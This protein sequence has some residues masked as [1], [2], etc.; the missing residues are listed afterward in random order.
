MAMTTVTVNAS[1]PVINAFTAAPNPIAVD[2]TVTLSWDVLGADTVRVLDGT[3]E[4]ANTTMNVGTVGVTVTSTLTVYTLEVANV[5][6]GNTSQV[7]VYGHNPAS[8]VSFTATPTSFVGTTTVTL[9]WNAV[10]VQNLGITLNGAPLSGFTPIANTMMTTN[11]TGTFDVVVSADATFV[12]SVDSLGGADSATVNVL[13]VIAET[14]PN[15]TPATAV[16]L[17]GAPIDGT[18]GL[19]GEDIDY[20][21]VTVPAGGWVRIETSDGMG[22]CG[23]DTFVD[24]FDT[25]GVTPLLSD[26]NGGNGNCSLIDP[27]FDTVARNMAGGTYYVA[28]TGSGAGAYQLDVTSGPAAC[29]NSLLETG[30]SCDDGNTVP[31]DGC[32][33]TCAIEP[34]NVYTAPGAPAT[35]AESIDPAGEQDFYRIVVTA[36]AI[37]TIETFVD[38][39]AGTCPSGTD[40]LIRLYD[41]N[42]NQIGSDDDDGVGACSLITPANDAAAVMAPGT[43]YLRVEEFGNNGVIPSYE[44]VFSSIAGNVCGNG[45]VEPANGE[46]CDDGNLSAGDGCDAT[47]QPELL[48]DY[49]APGAL[50]TAT[51]SLA[52]TQVDTIRITATSSV[53]IAAETLE[54]AVNGTCD[55]IDTR[56][57]LRDGTGVELGNDDADGVGSC[58]QIN[59]GDAFSRVGPGV[60]YLTI[61]E[62]GMNAAISGYTVGVIGI[63]VDVCGNG[64]IE[65]SLNEQ[66][67]D[68]NTTPGDGCNATCQQEVVATY[69]APGAPATITNAIAVVGEQDLY[70]ITVTAETYVDVETFVDAALGT[71]PFGTDTVIYLLDSTFTVLGSDDEGGENSCSAFGPDTDG[72]TRLMPGTYYVLVEEYLNNGTIAT[73]DIVFQSA[74]VDICGNGV[75]ETGV[76][77]ACDDGNTAN[78]DG[79]S[80]T[81]ALE[82]NV[83]S[84]VEPNGSIGTANDPGLTAIG[85]VTAAGV[86][87]LGQDQDF[88]VVTVPTGGADINIHTY[89]TLGDRTSCVS[90]TDTEV[91]LYDSTGTQLANNDDIGGGNFCSDLTVTGLTAGTYYISVE[92][93]SRSF[94]PTSPFPYFVDL[95]LQ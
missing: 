51:S 55:T 78:G 7:M 65:P 15:D 33:A 22:G 9:S 32:D 16:V 35:F 79:C 90:P 30:E 91:F 37:V 47:C 21:A 39:T 27:A 80:A 52:A 50:A 36:P 54:D 69:T 76:G 17:T 92:Y 73:Y 44:I 67:D 57:R 18:I 48:L 83:F 46:I 62:D 63:P 75:L 13:Q 84:E 42:A 61:E 31:G 41:S 34:V 12:L 58:S 95:T 82:G 8:V 87:D 53:Y 60:Y 86:V 1:A 10:N 4:L 81:C 45:I 23:L 59:P 26:D 49:T 94:D 20:Y 40:T 11:E 2:G 64:V 38:A 14:E 6:G 89:T 5:T 29:G 93:Y 88:Y 85:R 43:Y 66:C 77:E 28:V 24:L 74:P 70:Q 72:F 3:T 19:G 25:D 68:G 56:L 71:C